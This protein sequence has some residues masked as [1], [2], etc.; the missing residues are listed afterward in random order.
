MKPILF[1]FAFAATPAAQNFIRELALLEMDLRLAHEALGT[2][3]T[4]H[5]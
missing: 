2:A 4:L 1:T 5:E 3:L